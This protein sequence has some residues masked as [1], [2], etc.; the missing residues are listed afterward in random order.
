M[1]I[2]IYF[3]S[4]TG[5]TAWMTARLVEA[6]TARGDHVMAQS[7]ETFDAEATP[8]VTGDM[9]GLTFPTHSSFAAS[10]FRD[11]MARLPQATALPLFVITTAGYASGDTAWYAAQP[12]RARGYE[13]FLLANVL[14][15]NNFFIPPM[16]FLPV[17]PEKRVPRRLEKAQQKISR[18]ADLIHTQ[19]R[20]IEG[21]GLFGRLLG[22]QQRWSMQTF[23]K[24]LFKPFFADETCIECGWC[25]R[26]CPVD[27]ITTNEN[28]V[29]FGERCILCM[30]CYS[31]YPVHAIQA[32]QRT[33]N[34]P[35]YRRYTGPEGKRYTP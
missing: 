13:P 30:R 21:A 31:F 4:G 1:N 28:G 26:H 33:R 8:P 35:W 24:R 32:T 9:I 18:L 15:P 17:T 14:M 2:G 23:E 16:A 5:N 6:L 19:T 20:H 29:Q 11:F 3:F 12:L 7:C 34:T 25:T 27:N 10:V 22:L